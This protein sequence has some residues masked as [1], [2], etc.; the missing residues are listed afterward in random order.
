MNE[1]E[2]YM[3][4]KRNNKWLGI[5]D[6]KSLAFLVFYLVLIWNVIDLFKIRLEYKIYIFVCLSIPVIVLLCININSESAIDVMITIIKFML[7]NKIYVSNY[8]YVE[9][10]NKTSKIFLKNVK[11]N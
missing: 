11:K 5:I 3:N 4:Y 6:Y 1:K 8:S 2:I 7:K 10:V 9:D